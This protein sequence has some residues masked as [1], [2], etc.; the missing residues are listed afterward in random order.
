M[1]D[2]LI[3]GVMVIPAAGAYTSVS[4]VLFVDEAKVLEVGKGLE[5]NGALDEG[6]PQ[7]LGECVCRP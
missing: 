5:I 6:K 1:L 3:L 2:S 7:R 4:M